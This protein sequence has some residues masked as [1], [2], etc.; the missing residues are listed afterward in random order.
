MSKLQLLLI[1]I[2]FTAIAL[3]AVVLFGLNP[4]LDAGQENQSPVNSKPATLD[5]KNITY[6]I[7]NQPIKLINGYSEMEVAPGSASKIIT[8]YFGNEAVG[9]LN[10]DGTKDVAF[11]LTQETSGSG[12]FFYLASALKTSEGWQSAG[13][14]FL[15]DRIAPQ[16]DNINNGTITIN[17]VDRKPSEPMTATPSVGI[18]KY[19]IIKNGS[20]Q[21]I[22]MFDVPFTLSPGQDMKFSDGLIIGLKEIN[23]SRCKPGVMCI[24]AGELS[25]TFNVTGSTIGE[26][27]QEIKL[28]TAHNK[29]ITKGDYTFGLESATATTVTVIISKKTEVLGDCYVGGCSGQICSDKKDM[30]SMCEYSE[31]YACYKTATCE[32]QSDGQCGWTKTQELTACLGSK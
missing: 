30:V 9:D 25:A 18:S 32:R 12:T 8:R 1:V 27:A 19:F 2:L 17:Y 3:F 29:K 16:S 13:T 4:W 22:A 31:T 11:L 10:G 21:E 26:V 5:Y 28:G 23:D 14:V 7:E 6:I 20:L 24:W 15:G